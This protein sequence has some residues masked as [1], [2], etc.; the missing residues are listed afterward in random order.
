[1][2]ILVLLICGLCAGSNAV[3]IH[4]ISN[5][6]LST[7]PQGCQWNGKWYMPGEEMQKNPCEHCTCDP[8][9]A[10]LICYVIDCAMPPCVDAVQAPD[11]CCAVCPNGANC[12]TKNG[13]VIKAGHAYKP[14]LFTTCRCPENRFGFE[15]TTAICYDE[16]MLVSHA[17]RSFAAVLV[18]IV[19]VLVA[20]VVSTV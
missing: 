8:G 11:Q 6:K 5:T 3:D 15:A 14:D 7:P 20:L 9:T 1:M 19:S 2:A 13:T 4:V 17:S 18:S 12:R 16:H 10:Q